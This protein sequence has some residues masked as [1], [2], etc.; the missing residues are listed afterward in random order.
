MITPNDFKSGY[1][2]KYK[3]SIWE[4]LSYQRIKNAQR[5]AFVRAKLRNLFTGAALEENFD[6]WTNFEQ[7]DIE[8]R[9]SQYSYH[10]GDDYHFMDLE[11]YDQFS[12][13]AETLGDRRFYLTENLELFII[14]LDGKP[15][16]V[17]VPTF[18]DLKVIETGPDY[19]GDTATGGGKPA[20]LETGLK[21]NVPFFITQGETVRIDTR[22]NTYVE[23][24]ARERPA[25]NA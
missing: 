1:L 2:I 15:V 6:S 18:V 24:V 10:D 9:R 12:F 21:V 16:T 7:P 13:N 22:E 3:D 14:S 23:R 17:E 20:T 19:T 11:T 25:H 4:V 5:R 8:R